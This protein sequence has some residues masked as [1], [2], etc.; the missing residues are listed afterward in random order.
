MCW[1]GG[2]WASPGVT[3][4]P[5]LNARSSGQTRTEWPSVAGGNPPALIERVA[6]MKETATPARVAGGNPPALIE[7]IWR[8]M[9]PGSSRRVAGGNPPALIER[10]S[11]RCCARGR[12]PGVA[13]GNPP[14][15]IERAR[16][17]AV[18]P[19]CSCVA[20]GN[21]PALI[22]RAGRTPQLPWEAPRASPGV[23]P[24]PSL[25]AGGS[26]RDRQCDPGVAGGNPPALIERRARM[27]SDS[28]REER[29]RG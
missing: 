2:L 20:G 19:G 3:P 7:R 29:R 22:E 15:L 11:P 25:N 4:R 14:A 12:R 17:D 8:R 1:R 18:V 5:S 24:R 27:V 16:L 9:V 13:G 21:P 26:G 28:Q 6:G 23:T 10:R